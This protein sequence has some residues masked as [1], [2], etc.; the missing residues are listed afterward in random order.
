ALT[1]IFISSSFHYHIYIK[2][3]LTQHSSRTS[4]KRVLGPSDNPRIDPADGHHQLRTIPYRER[5]REIPTVNHAPILRS[6]IINQTFVP[7]SLEF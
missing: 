7:V 2:N 6:R 3:C 1:I 4:E 5:P